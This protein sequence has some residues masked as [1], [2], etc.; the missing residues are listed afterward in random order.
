MRETV[1][2]LLGAGAEGLLH[3]R[4]DAAHPARGAQQTA[5]AAAAAYLCK[6]IQD[7]PIRSGRVP[8]MSPA[9]AK[10]LRAVLNEVGA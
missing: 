4:L 9:A 3:E 10:A 2:Q 8:D 6:R 7:K 1:R 5:W